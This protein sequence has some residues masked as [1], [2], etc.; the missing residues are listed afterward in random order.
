MVQFFFPS[1]SVEMQV[2]LRE[3]FWQPEKSDYDHINVA[4]NL[5]FTC[6]VASQINE[7]FSTERN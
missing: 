5:Y 6:L 2:P 7:A 1:P 3:Y 4:C